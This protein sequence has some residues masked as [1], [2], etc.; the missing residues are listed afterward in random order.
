V[1]TITHSEPA[2]IAAPRRLVRL[3]FIISAVIVLNYLGGWV[4]MQI[5]FQVWPQHS[6]MIDLIIVAV[7]ITYVLSMMLPFVPGIEIGLALML[8]LGPGGVALVYGCTQIA[9]ALS[10]MIGRFVPM[11]AIAPVLRTLQLDR[12]ADMLLAVEKVDPAQRVQYLMSRAPRNWVSA[13]LRNRYLALAIVINLP[14]NAAMGGAGGIGA[15]A[16]MSRLFGFRHYLLVV[17]VATSPV[18][19]FL[20]L[21]NA[22]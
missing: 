13:L 8:F 3:A 15:I 4:V 20:L 22:V 1:S 21:G 9:L 12:A 11:R 10:F 14:G 17:F 18:P 6:D 16:G 5:N 2:A 7:V 19:A